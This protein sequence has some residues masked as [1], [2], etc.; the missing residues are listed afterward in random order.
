MKKRRRKKTAAVL[1]AGALCTAL[2]VRLC[3]GGSAG[4]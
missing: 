2:P 4:K 1:A 3:D